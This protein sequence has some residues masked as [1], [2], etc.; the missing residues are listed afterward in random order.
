MEWII[1]SLAGFVLIIAIFVAVWTVNRT[2]QPEPV[3]ED[4]YFNEEKI[5]A[6]IED[7]E[8]A[9][10]DFEAELADLNDRIYPLLKKLNQRN[11]VR[12]SKAKDKEEEGQYL[13]K[14][15][16][17]IIGYGRLQQ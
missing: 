13:N 14:P 7:C 11:M 1:L 2:K 9:V 16:G 4:V 6:R 12:D 17:G 5:L 8:K 10:N 15:N 3:E